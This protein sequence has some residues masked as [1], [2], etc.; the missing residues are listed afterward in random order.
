M[1]N[2]AIM[3]AW[4]PDAE[5]EIVDGATASSFNN[6]KQA[7]ALTVAQSLFCNVV[8]TVYKG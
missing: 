5:M 6:D 1:S 4:F 7:A 8:P 2:I 3:R